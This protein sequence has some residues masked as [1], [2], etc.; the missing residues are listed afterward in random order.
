MLLSIL[1]AKAQSLPAV[2]VQVPFTKSDANLCHPFP[3]SWARQDAPV[4]EG[5]TFLSVMLVSFCGFM[6][7]LL[8]CPSVGSCELCCSLLH[9]W[10]PEASESW[11]WSPAHGD[12]QS[13]CHFDVHLNKTR[14]DR[15][16]REL[17]ASV[18]KF[19][20]LVWF[21]LQALYQIP[22]LKKTNIFFTWLEAMSRAVQY[23]LHWKYFHLEQRQVMHSPVH[24]LW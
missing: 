15:L 7:S 4:Q 14:R 12:H 6:C 3:S 11:W 22:H 24:M 16:G 8:L 10:S 21:L 1:A 18:S 17:L 19:W 20:L 5:Q 23:G 9:L 2:I 13:W